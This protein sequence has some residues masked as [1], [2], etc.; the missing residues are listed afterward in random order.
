MGCDQLPSSTQDARHRREQHQRHRREHER[1]D[2]ILLRRAKASHPIQ[3]TTVTSAENT[4]VTTQRGSI[5]A[6]RGPGAR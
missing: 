2:E 6:Q 3:G 4:F 5:P 1:H